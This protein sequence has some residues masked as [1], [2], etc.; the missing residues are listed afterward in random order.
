MNCRYCQSAS[1]IKN[2]IRNNKQRFRCK[3]CNRSFLETYKYYGAKSETS[4]QIVKCVNN[5][6]GIRNISRILKVSTSTILKRIRSIGSKIKKPIQ[7]S[8]KSMFELDEMYT[9]IKTKE[10]V[11]WIIYAIERTTKQVVDFIVGR[12]TSENA[13]KVINEILSHLPF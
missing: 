1:I 11:Y 5:G 6:L 8:C 7:F 12:R 4:T 13:K 10:N 9:Y 3:K 2:G